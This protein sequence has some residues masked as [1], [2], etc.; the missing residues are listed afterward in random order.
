MVQHCCTI[1]KAVMQLAYKGNL[2]LDQQFQFRAVPKFRYRKAKKKLW[3]NKLTLLGS[4]GAI[5]L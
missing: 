1:T 2:L 4:S 5:Y 3:T